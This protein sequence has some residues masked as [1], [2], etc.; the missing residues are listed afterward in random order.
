MSELADLVGR[1]FVADQREIEKWKKKA[2]DI[3]EL[4]DRIPCK[5]PKD[6]GKMELCAICKAKYKA[7]YIVGDHENEKLSD[8]Q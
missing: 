1:A 3:K 5:Y 4:L 6:C 8:K 7:E 2:H